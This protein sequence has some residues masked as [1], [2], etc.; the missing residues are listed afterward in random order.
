MDKAL[1]PYGEMTLAETMTLGQTLAQ[2]GY[3]TDARQAAQAV[4]KVLAGRELGF[5]PI[6]SMTGINVIKGKVAV[7]ANLMAAS[8]KRDPRYNYHVAEM[9]AE[10]CEL[11]FFEQEIEIGRSVF[12]IEEARA[13]G[14]GSAKPPG[15]PASMLQMFPRNMLFARAMSNGVRWYCPDA[16]GG[17]PVY[18]P[19]ELGAVTDGET[20]TLIEM[21]QAPAPEHPAPPIIPGDANQAIAELYDD[22]DP[23]LAEAKREAEDLGRDAPTASRSWPSAI[24]KAVIG[25]HLAV[26]APNAVRMLNLSSVL[27]TTDE[28]ELVLTWANHYR[29]KREDGSEPAEAAEWADAQLEGIE[30]PA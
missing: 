23:D 8:V 14:V 20:G 22:Y 17:S 25:A 16:C 2:S 10:R 30:E 9:T 21:P 19:D 28:I 18:T 3:F 5:G 6:A 11:V 1:V 4:V 29:G 26:N 13:A 27:R 15:K 24:I 12:T 7:G